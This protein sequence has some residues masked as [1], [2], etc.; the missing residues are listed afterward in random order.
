MPALRAGERAQH[1][2][3]ELITDSG[4]KLVAIGDAAQLPSIGADGMFDRLA[5]IAPAGQLS[6]V[7]RTLDPAEQ[8]AWADL[9]RAGV[10]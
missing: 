4:G 1:C 3:T 6:N 7:R 9:D 2:L 5:Q 8:R 10:R